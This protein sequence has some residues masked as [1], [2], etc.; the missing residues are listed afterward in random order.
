[1]PCRMAMHHLDHPGHPGGGLG[2]ADVGLDRPQPQR[3]V[4]GGPAR[5]WRAAPGPR[6]GRP[7]SCR[8]RAP[9]PRRLSAGDSP[10]LASAA[11][12]TRSWEGPLGAVSPLLAPSWFTALPRITAR[13][14]C[15]LR[16]GVGQPLQQRASPRP[17]PSRCRRRPRRTPCSGRPATAPRCRLNS[18]KMLGVAMTVTPPARARSHS[19][20]RSAWQARCIATSEDEH[21]VSI[22]TAGP[23]QAQGVGDPAGGDAGGAAGA[24]VGLRPGRGRATAGQRSR[25]T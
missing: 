17:R 14:G 24:E 1:M 23:L 11:R 21:A 10:A 15:P 12:M 7:A 4:A 13:I 6:S 8:C 9:P 16:A 20:E 22:V 3:P 18:M 19:P 2:V 25:R 5:R